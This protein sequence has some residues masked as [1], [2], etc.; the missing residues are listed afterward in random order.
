MFIENLSQSLSSM[1][2]LKKPKDQQSLNSAYSTNQRLDDHNPLNEIQEDD[3]ENVDS[4]TNNEGA[5][6]GVTQI[7]SSNVPMQ[8]VTNEPADLRMHEGDDSSEDSGED[9]HANEG[10]LEIEQLLPSGEK[11]IQEVIEQDEEAKKEDL[12]K[13]CLL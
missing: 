8:D 13:A 5:I 6:G 7:F 3:N 4:V 9:N 2:V 12:E 11:E 10:G 1:L